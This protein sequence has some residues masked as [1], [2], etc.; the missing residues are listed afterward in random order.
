[1]LTLQVLLFMCLASLCHTCRLCM[2][3][4]PNVVVSQVMSL[5]MSIDISACLTHTSFG[6]L[7]Y[8]YLQRMPVWV[9]LIVLGSQVCQTGDIAG[10]GI[11]VILQ[12]V[13]D[14]HVVMDRTPSPAWALHISSLQFVTLYFCSYC[15]CSGRLLKRTP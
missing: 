4:T 11:Y 3:S 7:V 13:W 15:F 14:I 8:Y 9:L 1:M 12:G 10:I 2:L 5:Y 6:C